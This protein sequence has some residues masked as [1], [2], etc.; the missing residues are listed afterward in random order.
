MPEVDWVMPLVDASAGK[1]GAMM[2]RQRN[3]VKSTMAMDKRTE[4]RFQSV[5]SVRIP[6]HSDSSESASSLSAFESL[7]L[8]WNSSD[9]SEKRRVGMEQK[10]SI[11]DTGLPS[12][13]KTLRFRFHSRFVTNYTLV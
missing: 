6:P 1:N 3:A 7:R 4:V 8:R 2:D 12:Y 10:R 9:D 5:H 11:L 13:L